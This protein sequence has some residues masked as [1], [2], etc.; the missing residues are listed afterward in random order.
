[1]FQGCAACSTPG[2]RVGLCLCSRSG[3][4]RDMQHIHCANLQH[5]MLIWDT[6]GPYHCLAQG[7]ASIWFVLI[8][9]PGT[10]KAAC[11][12]LSP[13]RVCSSPDYF[14][15]LHLSFFSAVVNSYH[16]Q[17][18]APELLGYNL[19]KLCAGLSSSIYFSVGSNPVSVII[20]P[21]TGAL[22]LGA[23][24]VCLLSKLCSHW[25][26]LVWGRYNFI[27]KPAWPPKL[28]LPLLPTHNSHQNS[29]WDHAECRNT[30]P[31]PAGLP[32]VWQSQPQGFMHQ[33]CKKEEQEQ[34]NPWDINVC[35]P[36]LLLV[37]VEGFISACRTVSQP[38]HT[39]E[40]EV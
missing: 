22:C 24:V 37:L 31:S 26:P 23:Q 3:R 32:M 16:W 29:C 7:S 17:R 2:R 25:L 15:S 30:N 12:P 1:M 4:P 39:Q 5:T 19:Q 6:M 18:D 21:T 34:A 9:D 11:P 13:L 20:P 36:Y 27:W 10:C 33:G 40:K 35:F 38:L 14:W 28:S 8:N